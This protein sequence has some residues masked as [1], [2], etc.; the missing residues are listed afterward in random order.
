LVDSALLSLHVQQFAM[1]LVV[2]QGLLLFEM[3]IF[4]LQLENDHLQF[5]SFDSLPDRYLRLFLASL[6]VERLSDSFYSCDRVEFLL[7]HGELLGIQL[8]LI[9]WGFFSLFWQALHEFHVV[10]A[11]PLLLL[12]VFRNWLLFQNFSISNSFVIAKFED[13]SMT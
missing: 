6:V 4:G 11:H 8:Q 12:I 13:I 1:L 9:L 7:Q 3:L 2:Q 5:I 10:I